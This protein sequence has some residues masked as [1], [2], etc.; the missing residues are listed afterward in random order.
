MTAH[1]QEIS[2]NFQKFKDWT[3]N[4]SFIRMNELKNLGST[5]KPEPS[6][7]LRMEFTFWMNAEIE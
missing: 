2:S 4:T 7:N 3:K 1:I 6:A 5:R